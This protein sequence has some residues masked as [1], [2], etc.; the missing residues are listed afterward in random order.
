M[1]RRDFIKVI[2][3]TAVAWP[4]ETRAQQGERV[5]RIGVLTLY[6]LTDREVKLA[7]QRCSTLCKGWAGRRAATCKSSIAGVVVTPA[8]KRH[9]RQNWFVQRRM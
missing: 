1:R 4:I 3:G 2:G 9:L 6:S 8:E 5:R 7:L